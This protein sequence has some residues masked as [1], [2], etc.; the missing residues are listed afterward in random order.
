MTSLWQ[1]VLLRLVCVALGAMLAVEALDALG[2]FWS[3]PC[4]D[5]V[6]AWPFPWSLS[7]CH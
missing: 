6:S 3:S 1:H 2:L 4:I 5:T 7:T